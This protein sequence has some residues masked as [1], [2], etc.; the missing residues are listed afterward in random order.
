[1]NDKSIY[2]HVIKDTDLSNEKKCVF[3]IL[4]ITQD[5]I[6]HFT[7]FMSYCFK[8][9]IEFNEILH[10]AIYNIVCT[11]GNRLFSKKKKTFDV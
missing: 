10:Y 6:V 1:M 5:T 4:F 11:T 3:C 9:C 7:Y 8:F 2:L